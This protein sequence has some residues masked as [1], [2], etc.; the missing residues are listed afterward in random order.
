M[1]RSHRP[2]LPHGRLRDSEGRPAEGRLLRGLHLGPLET[3][4]L[5]HRRAPD[6][7]HAH[8]LTGPQTLPRQDPRRRHHPGRLGQ[9]IGQ[10]Q[11][12]MDSRR[13]RG[14]RRVR[15]RRVAQGRGP[16]AVRAAR[17]RERNRPHDRVPLERAHV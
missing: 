13:L 8:L 4:N 15:A 6:L 1:I 5:H 11:P 17:A 16:R 7:R 10:A 2:R 3:R 9:A 14:P 12:P